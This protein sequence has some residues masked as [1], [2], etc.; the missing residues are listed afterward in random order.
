MLA[1]EKRDPRLAAILAND[2]TVERLATGFLFTEGPVWHAGGQF[3]LFSDMPGD[4]LRRWSAADGISTFR[5]PCNKSN[6]L[7]YDREGRLLVCEHATS[8]V[9]RTE[10]DGTTK[11]LA[12]QPRAKPCRPWS[13]WTWRN[14][15]PYSH[16]SA[17]AAI[18]VGW[19]G[20]RS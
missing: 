8:R 14:S 10:A 9:T 16:R 2:A 20:N 5:K 1:L 19:R 7:T 12:R 17:L 11:V 3:L 15:W 18:S 4:H 6:G 13:I